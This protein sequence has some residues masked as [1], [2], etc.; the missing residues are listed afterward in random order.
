MREEEEVGDKGTLEDDGD[1]G[2]V[3]ELD[4][5]LWG[6]ISSHVLIFHVDWHLESLERLR[7][8]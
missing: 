4:V 6:L 1:V 3:E 2:G 5:V 7:R 8:G